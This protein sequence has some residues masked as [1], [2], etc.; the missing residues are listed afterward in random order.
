MTRGRYCDS[1]MDVETLCVVSQANYN[2]L[3]VGAAAEAV[4]DI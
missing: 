3:M 1:S 2:H 4:N